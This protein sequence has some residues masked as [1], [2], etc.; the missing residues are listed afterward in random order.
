MKKIKCQD[1]V[2]WTDKVCKYCQN[3]KYKDYHHICIKDSTIINPEDYC[4]SYK[5]I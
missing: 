2:L 5:K 3:Y 1:C 4:S